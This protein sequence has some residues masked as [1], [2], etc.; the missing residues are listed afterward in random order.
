M[1]WW[2]RG[3]TGLT[4]TAGAIPILIE[5]EHYPW[6]TTRQ[7]GP[8]WVRQ[9]ARPSTAT[10]FV[11]GG[12]KTCAMSNLT[13]ASTAEA[14]RILAARFAALIDGVTDWDVPT[15]VKE[16]T[17]GDV[18]DHLA[19]LPGM[20]GSMGVTLDVPAEGDRAQR[21]AAQTTAVQ[22]V[23]EAP[24]ADR[25]VDTGVMGPMPLS[26]IISQFYNFDLF[27]HG[28]DLARA[29]GQDDALD[30]EVAA[31]TLAAMRPN[32]EMLQASGQ[33]GPPQPVA[34]GAPMGEQLMAFLGRDPNW[35]P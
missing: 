17:A 3:A 13:A 6:P 23:L 19:W 18:V 12:C 26:Q 15:P 21:F 9:V 24:D 27:A 5:A 14:H 28:W 31:G 2:V 10:P 29:T 33:F 30:E 1:S 7:A 34:D 20:L 25:V 35:R 32:S 8:G 4:R 11:G 22:D 16:W